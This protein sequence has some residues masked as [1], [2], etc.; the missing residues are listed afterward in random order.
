MKCWAA[1]LGGCSSNI[2]R[3][4]YIS[5]GIFEG[6]TV[7]IKGFSWCKD[8][9]QIGFSSAVSNILCKKH[10]NSL[11]NFD[12]VASQLSKFL[13]E[14]LKNRK[15]QNNVLEINGKFLEKWAF[16]TYLNLGILGALDQCTFAKI[17][18][19]ESL[20]RYI[21][22]DSEI[23]QGVGIYSVGCNIHED[24]I[25]DSVTWKAI[26]NEREN[27]NIIGMQLSICGLCF[28]INTNPVTAEEPI[29][30]ITSNGTMTEFEYRPNQIILDN[31]HANTK[32]IKINW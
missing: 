7:L 9:R 25:G 10:N 17:E 28:I 31:G 13:R 24:W 30:I 3:E 6:K 14:N 4:H 1:C 32:T 20:V 19:V 27:N 26:R 8:Q 23:E 11:S 21:Y 16:K 5:D 22:C 12:H 29:K 15:L 2:T 18:P